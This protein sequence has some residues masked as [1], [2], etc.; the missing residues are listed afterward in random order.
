[1]TPWILF[2][3]FIFGPCEPLIP[4]LMYPAV[5]LNM[6]SVGIVAAVFSVCTIGTMLAI[7]TCAYLGLWRLS[8]AGLERYSHALAGAALTACGAAMVAG[9]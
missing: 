7:V 3:I 4:I 2:T 6:W 5:R 1:M 8:T 9:L